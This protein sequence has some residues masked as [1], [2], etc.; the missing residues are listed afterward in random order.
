MEVDAAGATDVGLAGVILLAPGFLPPQ[1]DGETAFAQSA[2]V[3]PGKVP[4]PN[5]PYEL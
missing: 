3:W 1:P 5:L 2:F 4:D